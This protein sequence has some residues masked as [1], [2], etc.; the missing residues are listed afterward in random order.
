MA[1]SQFANQS[2]S[3]SFRW[4]RLWAVA[5]GSAATATA[6]IAPLTLAQPLPVQ[7]DSE[8]VTRFTPLDNQV[9]IELNNETGAPL[10]YEVLGVTG[11]RMLLPTQSALLQNIPLDATITAI[12]KDSGLIDITGSSDTTGQLSLSI[13]RE[14]NFDDTQGVI[15]LEQNGRVFAY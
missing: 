5:F 11:Q 8:L 10:T 7:S 14:A 4:L 12:R 1:F 3:Q 15:I 6:A 9:T 2:V 13:V